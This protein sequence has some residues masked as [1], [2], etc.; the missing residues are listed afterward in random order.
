MCPT[1]VLQPATLSESGLEG[2]WTPVLD[3]SVGFCQLNCTLCSEVCPTGAIQ[4]ID[5]EKKLGIGKHEKAGPIRLGTAFFNRGRCLPWAMET[6][7]VVCEEVCEG[8]GR[9][10]GAGDG[11][12]GV[13][14]A[15]N[16]LCE[17]VGSGRCSVA[18]PRLGTEIEVGSDEVGESVDRGQARD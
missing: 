12:G 14:G 6:P 1:N 9:E 8:A 11:R 15:W 7:C 10:E 3:F 4:K 16:D 17:K 5:L 18:H 2:L 13:V